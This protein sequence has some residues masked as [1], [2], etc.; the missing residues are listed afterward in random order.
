MPKASNKYKKIKA[1]FNLIICCTLI[2]TILRL[3]YKF[4]L[5]RRLMFSFQKIC[6]GVK[7][8]NKKEIK[9]EIRNE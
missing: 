6:T 5:W 7:L 8:A 4:N 2:F 3:S 9:N 1:I